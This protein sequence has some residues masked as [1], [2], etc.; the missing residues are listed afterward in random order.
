MKLR[1]PWLIR[2]VAL[3]AAWVVR[4]W[5]NTLR[6][7][8]FFADGVRHPADHRQQRYLYAFWHESIL[9]PTTF[10]A[11]VHVLIGQHADAELMAQVCRFL[12]FRVVRG[13]TTRGGIGALLE[14]NRVSRVSHLAVTPDGPRGP[15]RR[16]QPGLV[17]LASLTGLPVVVVGVGYSSAWRARSWDRFA[18]PRPWSTAACVFAPA[19]QVPP[20]LR[21]DGL[22][23]Y[24]RLVEE[25]L[26]LATEAAERWA[27]GGPRPAGLPWDET[28]DVK[29]SA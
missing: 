19:I 2:P 27:Q 10:R 8:I 20:R 9:F 22:E 26:A 21:R 4:L 13:S 18:V 24:T 5:M 3:L 17:Y 15:R 14:L 29:A 7:R 25:R 6:Y 28:R 12:N 23:K 16:I 1:A 11:R